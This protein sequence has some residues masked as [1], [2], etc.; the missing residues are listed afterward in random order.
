MNGLLSKW[1]KTNWE[2][3]AHWVGQLGMNLATRVRFLATSYHQCQTGSGRPLHQREL[4]SVV[5]YGQR[6]PMTD[7]EWGGLH[8][9]VD[10]RTAVSYYYEEKN[11]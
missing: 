4:T 7:M 11:I 8:P 5:K 1:L 3:W 10:L 9:A 2:R 6:M